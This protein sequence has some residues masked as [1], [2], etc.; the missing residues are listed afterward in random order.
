MQ[1]EC[2]VLVGC[3]AGWPVRVPP[4]GLGPELEQHRASGPVGSGVDAGVAERRGVTFVSP[5]GL[6]ECRGEM[7]PLELA[8]CLGF[9]QQPVDLGYLAIVGIGIA[10]GQKIPG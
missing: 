5:E 2:V 3:L 4:G 7:D 9:V 8:R 6:R 1:K 10:D